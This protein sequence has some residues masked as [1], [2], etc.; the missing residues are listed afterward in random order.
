[1]QPATT[2]AVSADPRDILEELAE[3]LAR[4]VNEP[5]DSLGLNDES[6]SDSLNDAS[7]PDAL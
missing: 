5:H 3:E 1:M 4:E 7:E 6:D 2:P